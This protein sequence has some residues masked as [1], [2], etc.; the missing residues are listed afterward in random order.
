MSL[1]CQVHV[2]RWDVV[3]QHCA[4]SSWAQKYAEAFPSRHLNQYFNKISQQNHLALRV[5]YIQC[6]QKVFT[7]FLIVSVLLSVSN[8]NHNYPAIGTNY[9]LHWLNC[10]NTLN[11]EINK[12]KWRFV[13]SVVIT[14]P[15]HWKL[16]SFFFFFNI[17]AS[18]SL[19]LSP[20][21]AHDT[22]R[23]FLRIKD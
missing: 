2:A 7:P 10:N 17:H 14:N 19:S 20:F 4:G 16:C 1:S 18:L 11:M 3:D 13:V 15:F 5:F 6:A 22:E 12:K 9:R 21:F 23:Y 8:S